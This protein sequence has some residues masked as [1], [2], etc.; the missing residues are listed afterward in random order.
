MQTMMVKSGTRYRKATPAEIAEA[1]G[2]YAREAM[3]R[4]RPELTSPTDA[5]SHL[6]S[7][8][9]GRDYE[10]FSVLYLDNQLRLIA[11]VELFRG[12]IDS[13]AVYPR[14]VVKECLWR[15]AGSV[16]FAHNHPDAPARPSQADQAITKKLVAALALIDVRVLDHIIVGESAWFSFSQNGLL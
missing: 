12:T 11:A 8:Y 2:F 10:T 3:N 9:A 4:A 15:G 7:I 16:V 13:S 1:A 14:E 6:T 5:V